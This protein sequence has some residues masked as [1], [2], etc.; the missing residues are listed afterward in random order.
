MWHARSGYPEQLKERML[1]SYMDALRQ[2]I[3]VDEAVFREHLRKFVLF[4]ILQVGCGILFQRVKRHL[5]AS[6]PEANATI[7]AFTTLKGATRESTRETISLL[8]SS[9]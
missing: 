3:D 8:L 5:T 2:Y 9:T 1:S 4:R 7:S 6:R